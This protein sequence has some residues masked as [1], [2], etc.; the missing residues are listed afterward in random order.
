MRS[1]VEVANGLFAVI[2]LASEL[3]NTL[4][5]TLKKLYKLRFETYYG[6][7]QLASICS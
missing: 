7:L 2:I 3:E 1:R 5:L 6:S 4:A